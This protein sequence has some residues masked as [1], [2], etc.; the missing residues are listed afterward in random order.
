[1][2]QRRT[3]TERSEDVIF[4]YIDGYS[5][6]FQSDGFS[7]YR[8][9]AKRL[10]RLACLQH[11]KRKFLDCGDD[12]DA[13][14]VVRLINHL[15][16]KDHKHEIGKDGWTVEDNTRWRQEYAP[17]ILRIIRKKLDKMAAYPPEKMLPKSEKYTA[18]HYM[19]NE[20][21]AIENIFTRGDYHLDNNLVE[22]LN[23][24]IS[25][26]TS[27]RGSIAIYPS[28][29]A[30]RSSSDRIRE[31]S[32]EP[33]SIR[34]PARA[35]CKV[36]ASSTTYRTSSTRLRHCHLTLLLRNTETCYPINGN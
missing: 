14:V 30:T 15:Y 36:S 6:A 1:M 26:T 29:D 7:P 35:D 31:Q 12:F 21:E 9:L 16:H 17:P 10:I 11:V 27:S 33:C 13:K 18:V 3:R 19:L 23:R 34:L 5:N 4:D 25:L 20:W 22:R 2:S 28:P 24:Y 32:V 8:K